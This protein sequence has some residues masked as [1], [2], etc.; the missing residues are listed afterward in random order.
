MSEIIGIKHYIATRTV[1]FVLCKDDVGF[2]SCYCGP[3]NSHSEEDD[4]AFIQNY[5]AKVEKQVAQAV[6]NTS[7]DKYI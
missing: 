3:S 5:G 6:F 2:L 1:T 7:F 4:A